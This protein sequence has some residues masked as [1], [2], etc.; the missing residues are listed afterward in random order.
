M[1]CSHCDGLTVE[2]LLELH[3]EHKQEA[4]YIEEWFPKNAYYRHHPSIN[5]LRK[6][7]D[8]GCLLCQAIRA[9]LDTNQRADAILKFCESAESCSD[10]RICISYD[11]NIYRYN[12]LAANLEVM[13]V[14][15][16][17]D[18]SRPFGV[19]RRLKPEPDA[20]NQE[21]ERFIIPFSLARLPGKFLRYPT[22]RENNC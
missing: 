14:G 10:V 8:A 13:L 17:A 4:G 3:E 16:G 15:F 9:E 20:N 19:R 5:S 22:G 2:R 1:F 18:D 7:A 21:R 12:D 6:A 11:S